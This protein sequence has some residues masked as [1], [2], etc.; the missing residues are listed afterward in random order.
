MDPLLALTTLHVG[1][2]SLAQ[3]LP[4]ATRCRFR[5]AHGVQIWGRQTSARRSCT[6]G[7][8][9]RMDDD[10]A[11]TSLQ[12]HWLIPPRPA[13]SG[14]VRTCLSALGRA[15]PGLPVLGPAALA[16]NLATALV[17]SAEH[18]FGTLLPALPPRKEV[19]P[20][21]EFCSVLPSYAPRPSAAVRRIPSSLRARIGV[22]PRRQSSTELELGVPVMANCQCK[23]QLGVGGE[24]VHSR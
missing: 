18:H 21:I 17:P 23:V 24:R 14:N 19:S 3:S 13:A 6:G 4:P 20:P 10:P 5:A 7:S 11:Y 2:R 12:P 15:C 9:P 8:T 16:A 22:R 1:A